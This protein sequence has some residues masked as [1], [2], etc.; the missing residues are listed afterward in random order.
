MT[1]Y[2]GTVSTTLVDA[3]VR[4]WYVSRDGRL[5]IRTS[6]ADLFAEL[7]VARLNYCK[8]PSLMA[9]YYAAKQGLL[10]SDLHAWPT[11]SSVVTRLV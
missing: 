3:R 7:L 11:A 6:V 8:Y 5:V 1:L 4:E 10:N 2:T 9:G